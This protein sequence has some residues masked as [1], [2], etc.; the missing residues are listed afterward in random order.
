MILFAVKRSHIN[1]KTKFQQAVKHGYFSSGKRI[2]DMVFG[3]P[4]NSIFD[5]TCPKKTQS[6]MQNND[7]N[8]VPSNGWNPKMKGLEDDSTLLFQ[9]G[10]D[11]R[12]QI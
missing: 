2:S 6:F 9:R 10:D 7:W 11:F 1:L 4:S 3:F 5:N 12:F 8:P